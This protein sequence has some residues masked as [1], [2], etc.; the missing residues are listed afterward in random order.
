LGDEEGGGIDGMNWVVSSRIVGALASI[1]L[2]MPHKIQND[3]RLPQ[4][5]SSVD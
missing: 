5:V 3:D 4:H 2:H 1:T